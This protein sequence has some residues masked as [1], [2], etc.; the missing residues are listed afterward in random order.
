MLKTESGFVVI[1]YLVLGFLEGC[2]GDVEGFDDFLGLWCLLDS[3]TS[4]I[5]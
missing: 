2:G 5:L 4:L 3:I 1:G